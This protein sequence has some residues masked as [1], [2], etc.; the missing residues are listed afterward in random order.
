M[1]YTQMSFSKVFTKPM[2]LVQME[3]MGKRICKE[4]LMDSTLRETVESIILN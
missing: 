1:A 3:I 4:I 2:M